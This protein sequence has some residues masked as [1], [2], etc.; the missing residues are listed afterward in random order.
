M[1]GEEDVE[2]AHDAAVAGGGEV[3]GEGGEPHGDTRRGQ[4]RVLHHH[5]HAQAG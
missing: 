2:G 4:P 5:L 1:G 3:E